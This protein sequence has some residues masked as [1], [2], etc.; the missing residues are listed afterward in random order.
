[1]SE[2]LSPA[3]TL[4][5]TCACGKEIKARP[6]KGGGLKT[7]KRWKK[8]GD[9]V[10]RCPDCTKGSFLARSIRLSIVDVVSP[11]TRTKAEMYSALVSAS[12][13]LARFANWYVQR[14]FVTD[15]ALAWRHPAKF[16]AL[17]TYDY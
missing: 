7:P 10:F 5:I 6:A 1:M 17:P 2:T 13:D 12:S 15:P 14:L 11:E 3:A 8:V 4:T 16:P 9:D